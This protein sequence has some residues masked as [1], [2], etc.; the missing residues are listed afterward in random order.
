MRVQVFVPQMRLSGTNSRTR[1]VHKVKAQAEV[2]EDITVRQNRDETLDLRVSVQVCTTLPCG[3]SYSAR[4]NDICLSASLML[5]FG[6]IYSY[7]DYINLANNAITRVSPI[8]CFQSSVLQV[9]V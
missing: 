7:V 8:F 9:V 5:F 1:S 4:R 3:A 6:L 2:C